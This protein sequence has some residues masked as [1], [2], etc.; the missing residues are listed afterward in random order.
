MQIGAVQ[1]GKSTANP[2][3]VPRRRPVAFFSQGGVSPSRRHHHHLA[4]CK[5]LSTATPVLRPRPSASV[6][7]KP[8]Y[9]WSIDFPPL[10]QFHDDV[11]PPVFPPS[12]SSSPSPPAAA[13]P[14]FSPFSLPPSPVQR[15]AEQLPPPPP[16]PPPLRQSVRP[17]ES[18]LPWRCRRRTPR[19][20]CGPAS[21]KSAHTRITKEFNLLRFA[22]G[23]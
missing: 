14:L 6:R 17:S 23:R 12:L 18:S 7:R 4:V 13:H 10:C 22:R 19:L 3:S 2:L 20:F 16:P 21:W 9:Y 1:F 11:R 15:A 8:C 5:A